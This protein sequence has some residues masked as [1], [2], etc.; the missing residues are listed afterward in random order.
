MANNVD[1]DQTPRSA[2]SNMGL[3][4]LL[5]SVCSN[6]YLYGK[7]SLLQMSY[8]TCMGGK[9]VELH[10][11]VGSSSDCISKDR[12]FE[13]KLD[14]ITFVEIDHDIISTVILPLPLFQDGQLSVTSERCTQVQGCIQ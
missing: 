11:T 5:R 3:R 12:K 2:A 10:R 14:Y 1:T 6:I 7:V 4:Y 8:K 13:S 9:V